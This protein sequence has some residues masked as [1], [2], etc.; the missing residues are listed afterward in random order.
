MS[1]SKMSKKSRA[2][3]DF[4]ELIARIEQMLSPKGAVIKSPDYIRDLITNRLREVDASIK[5]PDGEST[6]LVTI[7]CR[8]HR[9]GRQDDRWIEQ[10][11]TKREKI[12]AWRTIAVSSSGF[13]D[14]AIAT[15]RHYGVEL[16]RLDQITDAEIAQEW[17]SNFHISLL[18]IEYAV[19]DIIIADSDGVIIPKE[20]L[21]T[22]LIA[23]WQVDPVHTN[24]LRNRTDGMLLSAADIANSGG[25][26][27]G[28]VE[29][30]K[31]IR[32]TW[33]AEF[34]S[35]DWCIDTLTGEKVVSR[36]T[37]DCEYRLR[38]VPAP[39][40]SVKQYSSFEKPLIEL[41]KSSVDVDDHSFSIEA[42][43]HLNKTLPMPVTHKRRAKKQADGE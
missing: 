8:D 35:D 40:Q 6:R 38:S 3:R 34:Q 31:P 19:L 17:A 27:P 39:I 32:Y 14:S 9:K 37:V 2:G 23:S 28:L 12:G 4:E 10:L 33:N 11:I 42:R 25:N 29:N 16:R 13:S 20:S 24:F 18:I 43:V 26:P 21:L 30:G 41:V 7:E 5:I 15:A 22:N 36:V 1:I